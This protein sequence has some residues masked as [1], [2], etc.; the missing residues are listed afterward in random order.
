MK[1]KLFPMQQAVI[2]QV[3][4]RPI[5]VCGRSYEPPTLSEILMAQVAVF[6]RTRTIADLTQSDLEYLDNYGK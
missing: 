6:G 1:T 3:F 5:W 2:G 4:K